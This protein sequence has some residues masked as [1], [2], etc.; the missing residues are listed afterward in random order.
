MI[1]PPAFGLVEWIL[2][3]IGTIIVN[4][5]PA[6]MPPTWALLAWAHLQEDVPVLPLALLGTAGATTG[7]FL[8]ALASRTF[9]NRIIPQR[10]KKNI[11][12][13]IDTIQSHKL[14]LA[15]VVVLPTNQLFIAAGLAR[16]PL[17]SLLV[18]FGVTRFA[19][20]V[21]WILVSDTAVTT[22]RDALQPTFGDSASIFAAVL[23]FVGL[24]VVMQIDWG[25]VLR[26]FTPRKAGTSD[27][28]KNRDAET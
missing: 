4:T 19:S 22:L 27:Q 14:G 21:V 17:L 1:V 5:I 12:T 15:S 3:G 16:A 13:L 6:F 18:A 26:R 10:W 28:G 23:S 20:Y 7:R 9:G 11:S 8:L 2:L 25:K 24:I